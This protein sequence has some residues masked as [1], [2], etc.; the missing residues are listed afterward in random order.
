[1]SGECVMS[2]FSD[3]VYV[4]ILCVQGEGTAEVGLGGR[5]QWR[6]DGELRDGVM[7]V[8]KDTGCIITHMLILH[9]CY[10]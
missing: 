8:N 2:A 6:V 9:V 4:V 1:M 5:S 7:D 10:F 3:G